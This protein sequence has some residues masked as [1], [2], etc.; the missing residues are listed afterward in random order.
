MGALRLGQTPEAAPNK[1]RQQ[2]PVIK[3]DGKQSSLP[4]PG[5]EEEGLAESISLRLSVP[6][7]S[8][9]SLLLNSYKKGQKMTHK[10]LP[11]CKPYCV[12]SFWLFLHK[13]SPKVEASISPEDRPSLGE[14]PL[15]APTPAA[16]G[17][18]SSRQ[19][20]A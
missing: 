12:G 9:D 11:S 13:L 18:P 1:P 20:G 8:T 7:A 15:Q 14:A 17:W 3:S 4:R 16:P 19:C 5:P 2:Q 10:A 6:Y